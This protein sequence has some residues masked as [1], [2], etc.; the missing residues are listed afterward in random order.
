MHI[1]RLNI[2]DGCDDMTKC[3]WLCDQICFMLWPVF[4]SFLFFPLKVL[5]MYM[6][7]W[8]IRWRWVD[9]NGVVCVTNM[10]R[11]VYEH[12][13]M[14]FDHTHIMSRPNVNNSVTPTLWLV[15]F[16]G[17]CNQI[18]RF[19]LTRWYYQPTYIKYVVTRSRWFINEIT[20]VCQSKLQEWYV[21]WLYI[22]KLCTRL[23]ILL[24]LYIHCLP[25]CRQGSNYN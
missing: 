25:R 13:Y 9:C 16:T 18:N 22:V 11:M 19:A 4:S 10:C 23:C 8:A 14:S 17:M 6:F 24:N 15:V 2:C 3:T 7:M 1:M 21:V 5:Y 20:Y 12:G